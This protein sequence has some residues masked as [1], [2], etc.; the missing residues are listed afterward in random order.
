M[1]VGCNEIEGG[2]NPCTEAEGPNHGNQFKIERR[3]G[4]GMAIQRR[5]NGEYLVSQRIPRR[6]ANSSHHA[7]AREV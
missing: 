5:H 3:R 7:H 4:K 2:C 1:T 6:T